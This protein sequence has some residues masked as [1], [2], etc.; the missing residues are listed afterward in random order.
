MISNFGLAG[1]QVGGDGE[2]GGSRAAAKVGRNWVSHFAIF[3]HDITLNFITIY[4]CNI[5]R[6]IKICTHEQYS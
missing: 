3:V 4:T 5:K 1:G 2:V 6:I